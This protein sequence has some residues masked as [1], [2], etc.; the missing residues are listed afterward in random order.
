MADSYL[1]TSESVSEGHP[2]KVADQISDAVLD[3]ILSEDRGARVA[4][5]TMIK[6]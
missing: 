5:E 2:D 3:A 4:C 6:T 1:F